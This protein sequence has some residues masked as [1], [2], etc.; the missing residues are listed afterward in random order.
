MKNTFFKQR[1]FYAVFLSVVLSVVLVAGAAGAVST[2]STNISTGGTLSVTGSATFTNMVN[3]SSTMVM[4][5]VARFEDQ[6]ILD[7]ATSDPT[8]V[9]AGA[10]YFD[11][12][13]NLIRVYDG[14][15]WNTVAT[16]TSASQAGGDLILASL[17][18]DTALENMIRLKD[19]GNGL[20]A[21]GT[22]SPVLD[23]GVIDDLALL[24]LQATSSTNVPLRIIASSSTPGLNVVRGN[25]T[26]LFDILSGD[27]T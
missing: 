11:S 22:T 25:P 14:T 8:G 24:T 20:M 2:I 21:L 6:M 7:S 1:S 16:S 5:G 13:N 17:G 10:L 18:S 12:T 4:D 26:N 23:S 15:A 27:G 9:E 19:I 3:G